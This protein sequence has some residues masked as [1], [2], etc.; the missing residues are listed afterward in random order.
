MD[1][2][3]T[4]HIY[5]SNLQMQFAIRQIWLHHI[6][7]R[8]VSVS[9]IHPKQ[10]HWNRC[11]HRFGPRKIE[12]RET[13]TNS[14]CI[15]FFFLLQCEVKSEVLHAWFSATMFARNIATDK[16]CLPPTFY[17]HASFFRFPLHPL[18]ST[19]THIHGASHTYGGT[20]T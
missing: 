4:R 14:R 13:C 6:Q 12:K 8:D 9:R 15:E 18:H 10:R 19:S 20:G 7:M 5:K 16:P 1:R 3:A 11:E 17:H 2:R